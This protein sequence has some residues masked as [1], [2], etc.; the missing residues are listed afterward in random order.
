[1][2]NASSSPTLAN[3][4]FSGNSVIGYGGGM[5]NSS[6]SPKLTNCII[7][8]NTASSSPQIYRLGGTVTVTCSDIQGGYAGVGNINVDPLF[9][10][11]PSPGPDGQWNGINDDY[12]DLRLQPG[13]PCIDRGN[14]VATGLAGI[15]TDLAGKPR[16]VDIALTPDAGAGTPPI[17]D[18]GAYEAQWACPPWLDPAGLAVWDAGDYS[19]DIGGGVL[20]VAADDGNRSE[21]LAGIRQAIALGRSTGAEI[22]S[23]AA[24][25]DRGVIAALDG[26]G[27][28]LMRVALLGDVTL[29]ERI[30]GDD[31]FAMDLAFLAGSGLRPEADVNVDGAVDGRDYLMLDLGFLRSAGG[32]VQQAA[33]QPAAG[34]FSTRSI[35]EELLIE[36]EAVLG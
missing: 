12:G 9:V 4:T 29:D 17:V 15:T 13:S 7:W 18:M 21:R 28:I 6:S 35:A 23:S 31:Y 33:Q 25:E 8:G 16:F 11:N 5:Y 19:L 20:T 22:V 36:E 2:Y 3:C 1:M 30:D 34:V 24:T 14:N 10:R 32:G 26:E 27:N